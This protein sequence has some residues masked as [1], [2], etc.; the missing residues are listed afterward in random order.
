M[1]PSPTRSRGWRKSRTCQFN[2]HQRSD[3]ME[4]DDHQ[5]HLILDTPCP[6]NLD[7]PFADEDDS[8]V[9]GYKQLPTCTIYTQS[10]A[11]HFFHPASKAL[12]QRQL[13]D[14]ATGMPTGS[15]VSA[16]RRHSTLNRVGTVTSSRSSKGHRSRTMPSHYTD[17]C[18]YRDRRQIDDQRGEPT[19]FRWNASVRIK[20]PRPSDTSHRKKSF[21]SVS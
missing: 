14:G 12:I 18:R 11:D 19:H 7:L 20:K 8:S 13:P 3:C 17:F 5:Q 6:D 15:V 4:A 9:G 1:P 21:D 16:L 2:W 10:A